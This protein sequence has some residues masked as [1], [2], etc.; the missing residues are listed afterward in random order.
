MLC[1][2][3]LVKSLF[4]DL[5]TMITLIRFFI[6][7]VDFYLKDF[8]NDLTFLHLRPAI[9]EGGLEIKN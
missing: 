8:Q 3:L 2:V 1:L 5:R 7:Q 6:F 4:S 9:N